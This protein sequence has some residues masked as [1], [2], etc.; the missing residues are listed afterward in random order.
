MVELSGRQQAGIAQEVIHCAQAGAARIADPAELHRR[1]FAGEGQQAVVAGMAGQVDQD[2][3]AI[4]GDFFRQG[5]V[6]QADD[7]MPVCDMA[8]QTLAD[9]VLDGVIGIG[10]QRQ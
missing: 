7:G 8:A 4:G 9:G 5:G 6:A 2:V 10:V 1:R 3:D